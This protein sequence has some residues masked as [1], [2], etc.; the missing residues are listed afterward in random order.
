MINQRQRYAINLRRGILEVGHSA[1][2]APISGRAPSQR[3]IL[4]ATNFTSLGVLFAL[5]LGLQALWRI[6]MELLATA[7]D[8]DFGL[9]GLVDLRCAKSASRAALKFF[10]DLLFLLREARRSWARC[11]WECRLVLV[12]A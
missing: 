9:R 5:E 4:G 2:V 6:R 12:L 8:L 1:T 3:L 11:E 7:V 10:E